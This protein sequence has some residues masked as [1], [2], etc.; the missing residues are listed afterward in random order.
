MKHTLGP[1][2][3]KP[4]GGGARVQIS[5]DIQKATIF[6]GVGDP[7][8]YGGTG[9]LLTY[10]GWSWLVTARHVAESLSDNPYWIRGNWGEPVH[11]DMTGA[12][13]HYHPDDNV[14]VAV[15]PYFARSGGVGNIPQDAILTDSDR[16]FYNVELGNFTYTIGL[17]RLLPGNLRALT[18]V[19]TGHIARIPDTDEPLGSAGK[20]GCASYLVQAP[21]LSGLSGSPVFVRRSHFLTAP[22]YLEETKVAAGGVALMGLWSGGYYGSPGSEYGLSASDKVPIGFGI[23]IPSERIVETMDDHLEKNLPGPSDEVLAEPDSG[24]PAK[25]KGDDVLRKML[26][27]LPKPKA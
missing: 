26:T 15:A 25:A 10:R 12:R 24:F 11:N 20:K 1:D 16:P 21:H 13:W 3:W 8:N 19:H 27:T 23:V 9:F 22:D 18:V 5:A 4:C 17:F 7:P 14:D 6:F 2:V